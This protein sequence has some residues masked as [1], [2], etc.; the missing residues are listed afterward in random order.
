MSAE[1]ELTASFRSGLEVLEEET[2]PVELLRR[3]RK[4]ESDHERLQ[5]WMQ[6]HEGAIHAL[7]RKG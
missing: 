5:R 2:A 7:E 6:R 3:I 4:L 1:T